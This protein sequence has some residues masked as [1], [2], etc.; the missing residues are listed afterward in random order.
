MGRFS[1]EPPC[2][3]GRPRP[4]LPNALGCSNDVEGPVLGA[5]WF[6]VDGVRIFAG[7]PLVGAENGWIVGVVIGA[8]LCDWAGPGRLCAHATQGR[9]VSMASP[10]AAAITRM[11]A[12]RSRRTLIALLSWRP[13]ARRKRQA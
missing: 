7:R 3:P 2:M 9:N 5:N 12:S 4:A 13:S 1:G 6:V 11:N 8:E 10:H